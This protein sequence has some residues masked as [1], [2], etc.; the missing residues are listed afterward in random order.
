MYSCFYQASSYSLNLTFSFCLYKSLH[1]A[2]G[3]WTKCNKYIWKSSLFCIHFDNWQHHFVLFKTYYSTIKFSSQKGDHAMIIHFEMDIDLYKN[4][5]CLVDAFA[6]DSMISSRSSA[7]SL[8]VNIITRSVSLWSPVR[9]R[10][11]VF[12]NFIAEWPFTGCKS[13]K[14][15]HGYI[16]TN[17]SRLPSA[18]QFRL[19]SLIMDQG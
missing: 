12:T 10:K 17:L 16:C 3:C 4:C 6:Y 9:L 7:Q 15:C 5:K 18:L 2:Y 19:S 8:H 13:H 14:D 11:Q 1:Y